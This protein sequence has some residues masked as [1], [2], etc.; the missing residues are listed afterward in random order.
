MVNVSNFKGFVEK[1][2][3]DINEKYDNFSVQLYNA[4]KK[5]R[6]NK[7]GKSKYKLFSLDE[8]FLDDNYDYNIGGQT[9][10][11]YHIRK[12]KSN[13]IYYGLG[14]SFEPSMSNPNPF[15]TVKPFTDVFLDKN[16]KIY[17]NKFIDRGY[18]FIH[19]SL[20]D[21]ENPKKN[22]YYL[23]GKSLVINNDEISDEDYDNILN[24]F[25]T[26]LFELYKKIFE[27]RNKFL[28][29]NDIQIDD[30]NDLLSKCQELLKSNYNLILTGAPGTGKT[31]LAKQIAASI[32]L[33]KEI[34]SYNELNS[35]EKVNIKNQMGFVQFHPSYDYTDFVEGIKP[36]KDKLFERQD[37][38]FKEFCKKALDEISYQSLDEDEDVDEIQDISEYDKNLVAYLKQYIDALKDEC[39]NNPVELKGFVGKNI[40]PL[41]D[42]GY[43]D[44]KIFFTIQNSK[45][46]KKSN[47]EARIDFFI[48]AY[49]RFIENDVFSYTQDSFVKQ[50][51]FWWSPA[52]FYGF[53]LKFYEK[54]NDELKKIKGG[55]YKEKK[56]VFIIDEIN[57]GDLNKILGE[58]FYALDPGY[59]GHEGMV[60]TQYSSLIDAVDDP[61]KHGFYIPENVYIIGTMNDIDRSVESMDFAIRRRFAWQ[62]VK[63]EDTADEILK[64][65]KID[66]V[67][68]VLNDFNETIADKDALGEMYQIG[69]SY[70]LKLNNYINDDKINDQESIKEAY[71]KLWDN[72]LKGLICE[73]VR[74]KRNSNEIFDKIQKKYFDLTE[75][76][77]VE[78][79]EDTEK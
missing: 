19:C 38:I 2:N 67:V 22:K 75:K 69:A 26:D 71:Q 59:R 9:E 40:S 12:S 36:T 11:Q 21:F 6:N 47:K 64:N 68:S 27:E 44:K 65:V 54:Y 14:F 34:N 57:R 77:N 17:L 32:I 63:P 73:Y 15:D 74:G 60:K 5:L 53:V 31:Y 24:D 61:F 10:V 58:L 78:N 13:Y 7:S 33:E 49:K 29:N 23:F 25:T 37:G 48:G 4:R 52:S 1:I 56:Y 16:F 70:F 72:H 39:K 76:N 3:R 46:G 50:I 18:N 79:N 66:N 62:E 20:D 28:E 42:A 8:K 55:D 51:K 45:T 43:N 41:V 35:E 30:E